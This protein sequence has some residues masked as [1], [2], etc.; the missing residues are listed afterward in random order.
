MYFLF[1][2]NPLTPEWNCM[3]PT[4]KFPGWFFNIPERSQVLKIN[5][6]RSNHTHKIRFSFLARGWRFSPPVNRFVVGNCYH[7]TY[8]LARMSVFKINVKQVA[9]LNSNMDVIN[10]Q[11]KY[12]LTELNKTSSK[13][14]N[15]TWCFY[16]Q[17]D[18]FLCALAHGHYVYLVIGALLGILFPYLRCVNYRSC[19]LVLMNIHAYIV[20]CF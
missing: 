18:F 8:L 15:I 19:F 4:P 16:C 17:C 10:C 3:P 20:S 14:A 7:K 6:M 11:I 1:S 2:F 13:T 12:R 5:H 9:F